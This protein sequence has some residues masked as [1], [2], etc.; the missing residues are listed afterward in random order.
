[1][2]KKIS[3]KVLKSTKIWESNEHSETFWTEASSHLSLYLKVHPLSSSIY[4]CWN[5]FRCPKTCA[6]TSTVKHALSPKSF[7]EGHPLNLEKFQHHKIH[8][9][10]PEDRQPSVHNIYLFIYLGLV[11]KLFQF[12][13]EIVKFLNCNCLA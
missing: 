1:M 12:R 3:R 11:F 5:I 4:Q 13:L 7:L 9:S 8:T 6:S 2:K 10:K